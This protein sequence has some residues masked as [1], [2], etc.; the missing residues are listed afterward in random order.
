MNEPFLVLHVTGTPWLGDFVIEPFFRK[1]RP[2]LEWGAK[3]AAR[4]R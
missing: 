1:H 2:V 4:S 3:M